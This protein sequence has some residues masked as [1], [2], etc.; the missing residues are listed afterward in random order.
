MTESDIWKHLNVSDDVLAKQFYS[1]PFQNRN[2]INEEIHGV[3]SMAREETPALLENSLRQLSDE[4]QN[5]PPHYRTIYQRASHPRINISATR[6]NDNENQSFENLVENVDEETRDRTD[7]EFFSE[8]EI[9]PVFS[10]TAPCY[11][12]SENF[13][14]AFLR[15]ELFDAKKAAMRMTKYLELVSDLYGEEALRR[16]LRIDDFKSKEEIDVLN[17]GFQQLLPFRDRS[18]RRVLFVHGDFTLPSSSLLSRSVL[19]KGPAMKVLL[20]LW[21]VLIEDVEA[22]RQGLVVIF[23]PR[24]NDNSNTKT[25]LEEDTSPSPVRKS[26]KKKKGNPKRASRKQRKSNQS[27]DYDSNQLSTLVPDSNSRSI[28]MGFF[29]AVPVRFCAFHLC[30][31]DIPFLRIVRHVM[32]LILGE[33]YRTR[34]K[35]HQGVGMEVIYSLMGYGIPV[36]TLPFD[37]VTL[38]L[39]TKNSASFIKVR[40]KIEEEQSN[41]Y[42]PS[43]DAVNDSNSSDV[44]ISSD[45]SNRSSM[46]E[47]P[48]LHDV[49]FRSGKSYMSHPGNMM[50]RELIEHHINEHNM[51][52][53]DRKKNLTWQVIEEVET[54]GGRF[55]EFNRS[56]GTWTELTDRAAVR[57][58]IATYFKEFR[59]KVKARQQ[60]QMNSSSTHEFEAQDGRK[61]KKQKQRTGYLPEN[62]FSNL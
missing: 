38:T 1:L 2:D 41:M 30:M 20:Y 29:E 37:E 23:W 44:S 54:K 56:L 36:D 60:I 43:S 4:L 39:K 48:S 59:R 8:Q 14:L 19:H 6:N 49:I 34:I 7:A 61:R 3:Q 16:P 15:C 5:L 40:Q 51:A 18:G 26:V 52:S 11:V 31:P 21:S 53:Q 42:N 55:L 13:Q 46:I 25:V 17:A 28:G 47:C 45:G 62:C 58:K 32:L 24:Y 57:H 10:S 12:K 22:Q 50:F 27:T 35:T 9:P 33:N